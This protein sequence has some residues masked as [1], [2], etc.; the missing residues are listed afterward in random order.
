ML[1]G[2]PDGVLV[3]RVGVTSHTSAWIV[4]EHPLEPDAHLRRSV[5]HDHLAGVKRVADPNAAAMME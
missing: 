3:S 1:F 2:S 4:G 5:G